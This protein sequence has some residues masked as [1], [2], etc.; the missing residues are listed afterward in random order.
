MRV[1][2][3]DL[4]QGAIADPDTQWSLGTFGAIAEFSRDRDEPV[5]L[6]QADDAV[7]AVTPRGGIVIRHHPRN[8]PL[9]SESITKSGWNQRIALCLT[10]DDGAMGG[11]TVL[12][13]LGA[14][15]DALRAEDRESVLFDLGLGAPHADFCVRVGDSDTAAQLRQHA[16]RA[17]FE[18]GNPAMGL[19]LAAN[20]HRV[21]LSRLGRIEVYQPIPHAS[22]KSPD[23]PHTH[24]LPKLLK[25]GRTHPA[26]E[27]I[28]EGWVPCAHLYPPHPARDGL[29]EP[30]P[31]D[32]ARHDSFQEIIERFGQP[33]TSAIKRR[34]MEAIDANEPPSALAQD[35][36]GRT[37]IRIALRQMKAAGHLSPALQSWIENFD[38]A[39]LESDADE[40]DLHHDR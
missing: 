8:R 23:G 37:T 33:E 36:H 6:R 2:T 11:R 35:R 38:P 32:A 17:V 20:P 5:A 26:T 28:P 30:R 21:F 12:T 10:D 34:I 22:G 29:G 9:A 7:S 27:P 13:E 19:I 4:L 15:R 3:I 24:V 18:P 39:G 16:G 40:A 14:D 25:S 1:A 31:F